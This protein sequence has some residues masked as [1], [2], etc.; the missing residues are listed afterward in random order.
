[1]KGPDG[2]IAGAAF[3]P[4]GQLLAVSHKDNTVR[5]WDTA[6][7]NCLKTLT[8]TEAIGSVAF[9][10][11]NVLALS[12]RDDNI[13]LW[14]IEDG[15]CL[16]SHNFPRVG[17]CKIEFDPSG[18]KVIFDAGQL[19]IQGPDDEG[20]DPQLVDTGFSLSKDTKW[21]TWRGEKVLWLPSS[22]HPACWLIAGSTVAIGCTS[23]SVV[24]LKFGD[25]RRQ[26]EYSSRAPCYLSMLSMRYSV[27]NQAR[28]SLPP[29]RHQTCTSPPYSPSSATPR[30]L[31][32]P[33]H[34]KTL[35]GS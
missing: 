3:S 8:S 22:V 16:Q 17:T 34:Q 20:S 14:S 29:H 23:G 19:S 12:T 24:V 28:P 6:F 30:L 31:A 13:Q 18:S 15:K 35:G 27:E 4:N 1:L 5:I 10:R 9:S 25:M 11:D 21:V 33:A 7:G 32:T 26:H 2:P